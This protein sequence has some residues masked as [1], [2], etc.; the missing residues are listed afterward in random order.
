VVALQTP[1]GLPVKVTIGVSKYD[2]E[3]LAREWKMKPKDVVD[4]Y[5]GLAS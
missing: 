1:F 3:R 4:A 5:S 2:G